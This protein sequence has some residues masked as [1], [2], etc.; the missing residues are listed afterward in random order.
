MKVS[1][2]I[3]VYNVE[4]Y[5]TECLES[6]ARQTYRGEME[7]LIVDDCGT[8]NSIAVAEKF[9]QSYHGSIA[10]RI[11]HHEHNR[12]LSAARNTGV[13]AATG[14]YV[15][16]LD[17]DDTIIPEAIEL[18]TSVVLKHPLAQMVQGGIMSM[19][20]SPSDDF[21]KR[22]LPEY[23][24][25]VKWIMD[26]MLYYLPVS[27][28]NRLLKRDFLIKEGISFHEGIIHEDVL[29][30][31][32]LAL[33]CSC[34]GFVKQNTYLFR[35][36]R[37]GSITNTP[38]E[39]RAL[40][41]RLIIMNDCIDTYLSHRFETDELK[42]LVLKALWSKW[43]NYMMIHCQEVLSH[44][45]SNISKVSKRMMSI[46][47]YP[48]K[49]GAMLYHSLPIRLRGNRAIIKVVSSLTKC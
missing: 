5:I 13:E 2:I 23:T 7:C 28:C 22:Q 25:N 37:E 18:M 43:L 20:G 38:Q 47:P 44:H 4:A 16:F 33:K 9:I 48:Q 8:D 29:Y 41:S 34:V 31:F 3:P 40:L 11:I 42:S 6:V 14:D 24:V 36:Q 45:L 1:I 15:Y 30:N 10:F 49:C 21:T 46:T 35:P 32:L 26:K 19:N 39:E 17:S 12:G 27:S